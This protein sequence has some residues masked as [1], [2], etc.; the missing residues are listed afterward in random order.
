MRVLLAT[1]DF[2]PMTGGIAL[3]LGRLVDH[4]ERVDFDVL[5]PAP[6][7]GGQD[8]TGD[9]VDV[10]RT[11]HTGHHRADVALLNA[12]VARAALR[13][14]YDAVLSGHVVAGPGGLLA[15]RLGGPPVVQY[16][17]AK[18]M[19]ARPGLTAAVLARADATI[20]I[21][22]FS[23]AQASAA[24][25]PADRLHLVLPGVDVPAPRANG[26]AARDTATVVTVAR[27]EDHYKGFDVMLRALPLVA[28]RAPSVRWVVVGD[29]SLR[30]ELQATADAWG[31]GDRVLFTG[32]VSDTER[33]AWLDRASV[34]A[35]PSRLTA[36]AGGGEG[37]GI[38][39]LEAGSHRLPCVAGGV[40]GASD[41]VR[42]GATGLLVDPTDHV[43]VA[44]ALS[45]VLTDP[46]LARE[47]GEA[48]CA[49][50]A[51]L[52]WRRMARRVEEVLDT[53]VER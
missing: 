35:M 26:G 1:P 17:Y 20:S 27:L 14:G 4:S 10:R 44:D 30:T 45:R 48:G 50:A 32:S 39:Y 6:Y 29:G 46:R 23:R 40:G 24:G 5:A 2:P 21:S 43:A 25:A 13:G 51:G 34:F 16:V 49:R 18:E 42:D 7:R 41:A 8:G 22:E 52:G 19:S 11:P 28:S 37:F 53:V 9:A 31:L 33:D 47:L 12:R 36:S 38:V 15:R 3:L